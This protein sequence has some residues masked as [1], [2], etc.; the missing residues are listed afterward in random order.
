MRLK[1]FKYLTRVNRLMEQGCCRCTWDHLPSN[2]G[3]S[4]LPMVLLLWQFQMTIGP[5]ESGTLGQDEERTQFILK[6]GHFLCLPCPSASIPLQHGGFVPREQGA[7]AT[8]TATTTETSLK[9]WSRAASNFIALNPPRS[10]RQ[11]LEIFLELNS[12][13]LYQSS[14]S[15]GLVFTSSTKREILHFHVLDVQWRQRNVGK[16]VM[17]V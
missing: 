7:R 5:F 13:R 3:S 4:S 16:S 6:N 17:H 9:K 2:E 12:K 8:T 14:E 1:T 15:C 10:I 11:M